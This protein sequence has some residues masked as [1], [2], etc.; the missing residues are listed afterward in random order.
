[1][2]QTI[3]YHPADTRIGRVARVDAC[4]AVVLTE[5]GP[6]RSGFGASLLCAIARNVT[7]APCP[8][9]FVVLRDWPDHRTTLEA[10]LPRSTTGTAMTSDSAG[11]LVVLP[12]EGAAGD[13]DAL[14]AADTE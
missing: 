8:G 7:A 2:L 6:V 4:I 9:D 13:T 14:G 3:G 12:G 10:V 1:M 11:G 5:D